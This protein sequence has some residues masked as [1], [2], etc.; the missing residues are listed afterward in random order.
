MSG[1]LVGSLL[2]CVSAP[3]FAQASLWQERKMAVESLTDKQDKTARAFNGTGPRRMGEESLSS[4]A[5]FGIEIPQELGKVTESWSKEG[6]GSGASS[7][8]PLVI[9]IQDAHGIY[10]AHKNSASILKILAAGS[11][12]GSEPGL[13]VCVEGAWE[14]VTPEWL[15]LFP[16][17]AA[18]RETAESFLE[19]GE[20][21]GEEYFSALEPAGKIR[22]EGVEEREIYEANL[23]AR[24]LVDENRK[25]ILA[26]CSLNDERMDR[27]K[28]ILYGPRLLDLS[29]AS[30]QFNSQKISLKEYFGYLR[31]ISP[32]GL[33]PQTYPNLAVL[34]QALDLEDSVSARK[35]ESERE[36]LLKVLEEK[37]DKRAV[38]AL[39]QASLNFRMGKIS[40]LNYHEGLAGLAGIHGIPA[41]L[42][43]QYVLYLKKA[44][45]TDLSLARKELSDLE[46]GAFAQCAGESAPVK[47]LVRMD[48]FAREL[49]KFWDERFSPQ[50]WADYGEERKTGALKDGF[51]EIER[52]LEKEEKRLGISAAKIPP[53]FSVAE[54][55][56][57]RFLQESYYKLAFKRDKKMAENTLKEAR[58]AGR[59]KVVLIAGG[60]H[61]SGMTSVLRELGAPYVVIQPRLDAEKPRGEDP[62]GREVS[63]KKFGSLVRDYIQRLEELKKT[64]ED[65]NLARHLDQIIRIVKDRLFFAG[66]VERDGKTYVL[67]AYQGDESRIN[68]VM[69]YSARAG[70]SGEKYVATDFQD[71]LKASMG[72]LREMSGTS[73]MFQKPEG[74]VPPLAETIGQWLA[75]PGRRLAQVYHGSKVRKIF[76]AGKAFE[77]RS[78]GLG[79]G[80]LKTTWPRF[81]RAVVSPGNPSMITFDPDPEVARLEELARKSR[82]AS[83]PLNRARPEQPE[84]FK[85]HADKTDKEPRHE[86]IISALEYLNEHGGRDLAQVGEMFADG[87]EQSLRVV[88]VKGVRFV[89][90]PYNNRL[91]QKI[92]GLGIHPGIVPTAAMKA[93]EYYHYELDLTQ[94]KTVHRLERF[95]DQVK[96]GIYSESFL[97]EVHRNALSALQ[98]INE[99][100]LS[101][102]HP[103]N[104]NFYFDARTGEVFLS[105]WSLLDETDSDFPRS[106]DFSNASLVGKKAAGL[107]LKGV[108]LQ[109]FPPYYRE[110]DFSGSDMSGVNLRKTYLRGA[111]FKGTVLFQADLSGAD[112]RGADLSG[113]NLTG[114]NLSGIKV[115]K[116]TVFP[117]FYSRV[118]FWVSWVRN[119]RDLGRYTSIFLVPFILA[120]MA[121]PSIAFAAESLPLRV[122]EA[123]M[124]PAA[125]LEPL[126]TGI[127][128]AMG[129]MRIM[130]G[131]GDESGRAPYSVDLAELERL[132][133]L[134]Y[135]S[136]PDREYA[137]SAAKRAAAWGAGENA[138]IAALLHKLP[139]KQRRAVLRGIGNIA[140]RRGTENLAARLDLVLKIPYRPFRTGA[141]D[142]VQ[143]QMDVILKSAGSE[144]ALILVFAERLAALEAATA[145]QAVRV[146]SNLQL[147]IRHVFAPLADRIGREDIAQVFW[148]TSLKK[149]IGEEK[150]A[151]LLD[152]IGTHNPDEISSNVEIWLKAKGISYERVM[153]RIKEPSGVALKL[154]RKGMEEAEKQEKILNDIIAVTVILPDQSQIDRAVSEEI[155]HSIVP[156]VEW[157]VDRQTKLDFNQANINFGGNEIKL[158]TDPDFQNWRSG[159]SAHWA[160]K[161][162]QDLIEHGY[163]WTPQKFSDPA[164]TLTDNNSENFRRVYDSVKDKKIILGYDERTGHVWPICEKT[165][166]LPAGSSLRLYRID[167][168]RPARNLAPGGDFRNLSDEIRKLREKQILD[169]QIGS[170]EGHTVITLSFSYDAPGLLH[171][172]LGA[173]L[174]VGDVLSIKQQPSRIGKGIEIVLQPLSELEEDWDKMERELKKITVSREET[175]EAEESAAKRADILIEA[176]DR[177]GMIYDLT[178]AMLSAGRIDIKTLSTSEGR[179][180]NE[181]VV[182]KLK[183]LLQSIL[184]QVGKLADRGKGEGKIFTI[185]MTVDLPQGVSSSDLAKKIADTDGVH[186]VRVVREVDLKSH[187]S[188]AFSLRHNAWAKRMADA[189]GIAGTILAGAAF[190]P[191]WDLS[192]LSQSLV[193]ASGLALAAAGLGS[194]WIYGLDRRRALEAKKDFHEA[195]EFLDLKDQEKIQAA[196]EIGKR[197]SAAGLNG[198]EVQVNSDLGKG[199]NPE[200]RVTGSERLEVAEWIAWLVNLRHPGDVKFQKLKENVLRTVLDRHE[201]LRL[202]ANRSPVFSLFSK[203]PGFQTIS[204]Y[205]ARA[206]LEILDRFRHKYFEAFRNEVFVPAGLNLKNAGVEMFVLDK[207]NPL[208]LA[209]SVKNR[210]TDGFEQGRFGS[211]IF[212]DGNLIALMNQMIGKRGVDLFMNRLQRKLASVSG[213]RKGYLAWRHGGDEFALALPAG[214]PLGEI[215]K[216][217]DEIKAEIEGGKFIAVALA[218]RAPPFAAEAAE[219]L[220][221]TLST[222]Q[223][224]AQ[225][226]LIIPVENA[227]SVQTAQD[228]DYLIQKFI[229]E[230]NRRLDARGAPPIVRRGHSYLDE[231]GFQENFHKMLGLTL[232]VGVATEHHSDWPGTAPKGRFGRA[233]AVSGEAKDVS[234]EVFKE[235]TVASVEINTPKK[236]GAG[237]QSVLKTDEARK[238]SAEFQELHVRS[239]KSR[240]GEIPGWS[241]EGSTVYFAEQTPWR[242][243][244]AEE[245]SRRV[246]VFAVAFGGYR[247]QDGKLEKYRMEHEAQSRDW[248]IETRDFKVINEALGYQAGDEVLDLTRYEAVRTHPFTG[249]RLYLVRGL[250]SGPYGALIPERDNLN[251]FSNRQVESA[252]REYARRINQSFSSNHIDVRAENVMAVWD[253][254]GESQAL[255]AVL[256][257]VDQTRFVKE[258]RP[259]ADRD[260][261][262]IEVFSH[263]SEIEPQAAE[264]ALE[265]ASDAVDTWV[266]FFD[267]P[268]PPPS[269]SRPSITVRYGEE[270]DLTRVLEAHKKAWKAVPDLANLYTVEQLADLVKK[271]PMSLLAAEIDGEVVGVLFS[272][273][274]KTNGNPRAIGERSWEEIVTPKPLD[275]AADTRVFYAVGTAHTAAS[276]GVNVAGLI[277][278]EA[279]KI[280]EEQEKGVQYFYTL[281]PTNYGKIEDA[282]TR[283]LKKEARDE[284]PIEEYRKYLA[285]LA[286]LR[287][288]HPDLT[289]EE[290][291]LQFGMPFHLNFKMANGRWLDPT[292]NLHLRNGAKVGAILPGVRPDS[293]YNAS[294]DYNTPPSSDG[295]KSGGKGIRLPGLRRVLDWLS[296][297]AVAIALFLFLLMIPSAADGYSG[298]FGDGKSWR[299]QTPEVQ[300]MEIENIMPAIEMN[301][302]GRLVPALNASPSIVPGFAAVPGGGTAVVFNIKHGLLAAASS[303]NPLKRQM[304]IAFMNGKI[305]PMSAMSLLLLGAPILFGGLARQMYWIAANPL[306]TL[307]GAGQILRQSLAVVLERFV[308]RRRGS[309]S[310][311]RQKDIETIARALDEPAPPAA[312]VSELALETL[313]NQ[314]GTLPVINVADWAAMGGEIRRFLAET[315]GNETRGASLALVT[316]E[317][318]MT[319]KEA[320]DQISARGMDP[321]RVAILNQEMKEGKFDLERLKKDNSQVFGPRPVL[322]IHGYDLWEGVGNILQIVF[323]PVDTRLAEWLEKTV[324]LR[325]SFEDKENLKKEF[326]EAFNL[327]SRREAAFAEVR[328]VNVQQ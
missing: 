300:S 84:L 287:A 26:R 318:L 312:R 31:K 88:S 124:H 175:L 295:S 265:R 282:L 46:K 163:F 212:F 286:A 6:A 254:F 324:G 301:E 245:V 297:R 314:P 247:D 298:V 82:E 285:G 158:M 92:V 220:G 83:L 77:I 50:D 237:G 253:R 48:G 299:E 233:L 270:L 203:V 311:S 109:G 263:A 183:V 80:G 289:E 242:R 209:E 21:T 196:E 260:P 45:E 128:A 23:K 219:D 135:G 252:L 225:D 20:M 100:K 230:I 73:T 143:N 8:L 326:M 65:E 325:L 267:K 269:S 15:N 194:S 130:K 146:E 291:D 86:D 41:P 160:Y 145:W 202:K 53:A 234:K 156:G 103:H 192:L 288:E 224:S 129:M 91:I 272:S 302:G 296:P 94:F 273:Q 231:E 125:A 74:L 182:A 315:Q 204:I 51:D 134:V 205:S 62:R 189:L 140:D 132:S 117:S 171:K 78:N 227:Q 316:D 37:L 2:F 107:N 44:R 191:G 236:R 39:A 185:H 169:V 216:I 61:T 152:M 72:T 36:N 170:R 126:M 159:K 229:S 239:L 241:E 47:D 208:P 42:M 168:A 133:K 235:T 137:L 93:G 63:E 114:A 162:E 24:N 262:G 116:H 264:I 232:S 198:V 167:F 10:G 313:R 284:S 151:A 306:Q 28:K 18:K 193:L 101:H 275:E 155:G 12:S 108:F 111:K 206:F 139:E 280:F 150:F 142:I 173:L 56:S 181:G 5:A 261:S 177:R 68:F 112:L 121:I 215:E 257:R 33:N 1:G 52:Y 308:G 141:D 186:D 246:I 14:R 25:S 147:Q 266:R 40:S 201:F 99:L 218:G 122:S 95:E 59:E 13:L 98:A 35:V 19:K 104:G 323:K 29:V 165:P 240:T 197:L 144:D 268:I 64:G 188:R 58:K 113:A 81:L 43:G 60:F 251:P 4:A 16:D 309:A 69:E 277:I 304:G 248:R 249:Y 180:E 154:I 250:L 153:V 294:Y 210:L 105:D 307:A 3:P 87:E 244:I 305:A 179:I 71:A 127:F 161:L 281:S 259:L 22:I 238:K 322:L 11:S 174:P 172:V 119:G 115:D 85:N 319:V 226:V 176:Q 223:Y 190:L 106:F 54:R 57:M 30:G 110:A 293:L 75:G 136:S 222:V 157:E 199:G 17:E 321:D 27:L 9:H 256:A 149:L 70:G 228:R 274:L 178:G 131:P 90:K 221:G 34:S 79:V 292:A 283:E 290:F 279:K 328:L 166:E 49:G 200:A 310:E 317:R 148:N 243:A 214:M 213:S 7:G 258:A 211:L 66:P 55:Q 271:N 276:K 195:R 96:Q 89:E 187:P 120:G 67:G 327:D 207:G 184:D 138:V 102:S 32:S 97:R 255:G 38:Y 278:K 320:R 164:L 76:G 123:L 303:P 217:A 118:G